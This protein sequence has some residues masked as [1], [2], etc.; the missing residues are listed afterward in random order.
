MDFK[1]GQSNLTWPSFPQ[2]YMIHSA[3]T[4]LEPSVDT[5]WSSYVIRPPIADK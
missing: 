5:T 1:S 3:A 2:L 4:P